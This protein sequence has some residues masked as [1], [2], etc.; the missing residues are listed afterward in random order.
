MV[1]GPLIA[2]L[3]FASPAGADAAALQP[4][5]KWVVDYADTQCTA[6]RSFGTADKPLH[7][8]IKPSPTSDVVQIALVS[9][10]RPKPGTQEEV[11]LKLGARV[12]VKAKMLEYG[13]EKTNV[14]LI[15]LNGDLAAQMAQETS[16]EWSSRASQTS[17][18]TGPL[19]ALMKTLADCRRDLRIHWN[20]DEAKQ[21]TFRSRAKASIWKLFRAGDY[22]AQAFQQ[23]E[24]GTTAVVLL[25]DE[26]GAVK[27]CMVE[28][29]S[30]IP[31]LDAMSC[32]VIRKRARFEPAIGVD[33]KPVRD[34]VTTRIRWEMP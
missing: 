31:T 16:F 12:P 5:G 8:L 13:A 32:I 15:N 1:R 14:Q 10:G 21:A 34:S 29:T 19:N 33:G 17:L 26:K 27:E 23:G 7:F 6:T 4:T 30:G 9:A 24:G 3:L 28:G 2:S 25:I 18:N 20:I 22:P 11:A